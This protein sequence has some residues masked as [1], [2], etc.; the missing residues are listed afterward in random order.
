MELLKMTNP[1][2]YIIMRED[3]W[4]MNPGKA[5][6]QASHATSDFENY[7]P[8]TGGI[9]DPLAT[10]FEC[11]SFGTTIVLEAPMSDF[12]RITASTAH[13][14]VVTDPTYPYRNYYGKLFTCSAVTCMWVFATTDEELEYMKQWRLH[15]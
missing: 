5:M 6:A 13:N 3:L 2:L 14:G 4:D 15:P 10:W 11:R 12:E 1:C 9:W 8:S 7:E